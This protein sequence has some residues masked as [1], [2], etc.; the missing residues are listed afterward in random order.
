MTPFSHPKITLRGLGTFRGSDG[1][2]IGYTRARARTHAHT[3]THTHTHT[4]GQ[5][6][7]LMVICRERHVCP[8]F[9]PISTPKPAHFQGFH[10]ILPVTIS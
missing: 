3:H 6:K 7:R 4:F 9:S 5:T 1:Q 8:F 10:H 2:K